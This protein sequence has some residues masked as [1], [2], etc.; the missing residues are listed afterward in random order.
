MKLCLQCSASFACEDWHCPRCSWRP[1]TIDG[2]PAF[3]PQLAHENS[4]FA[5]GYF[6]QIALLETGHF[7][8]ES[9]NDIIAWAIRKYCPK[10][11]S[12]LEVGCGTGFVLTSIS[13]LFPAARARGS[14]VFCSGLA[15]ASR[16]VP[17]AELFQMDARQ[18]PFREEFDA[19]GTF[20]VLEHID[21]DAGTLLQL[22]QAVRPGGTMI[23]T[24]PQH[25]FL[26]TAIDDFS[27]HKRRYTRAELVRKVRTAGFEIAHVT[28]FVSLLLPLLIVSRLGMQKRAARL[29]P[30]AELRIAPMLNRCLR[31]VMRLERQLVRW[32]SLP[33][34]GSLL[35]V[36]RRPSET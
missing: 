8:F 32:F 2:R 1:A 15:C 30:G 13:K 16:R 21:D 34:G 14:E 6:E 26:W 10:M 19:I 35:L 12:F 4:G 7:W 11:R 22:F 5:E 23:I 20:D 17:N 3:A 29:E 9:R 36:A 31:L 25:P 27:F 33:V 18:I 28:S 24:V